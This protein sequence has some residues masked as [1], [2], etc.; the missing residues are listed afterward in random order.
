MVFP[1]PNDR[2]TVCPATVSEVNPLT[3]V[4]GMLALTTTPSLALVVVVAVYTVEAWPW[5]SVS[6]EAT[7]N[8][9]PVESFVMLKSTVCPSTKLFWASRTVTVMV[10]VP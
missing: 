4:P 7:D 8:D 1:V 3:V 5:E 6:A 10:L 2:N 9:P